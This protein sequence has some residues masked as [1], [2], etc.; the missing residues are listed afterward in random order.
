MNQKG[1]RKHTD[2]DAYK[3]FVFR[4]WIWQFMLRASTGRRSVWVWKSC[5]KPWM[6]LFLFLKFISIL[7]E[8]Y[9]VKFCGGNKFAE[10][11]FTGSKV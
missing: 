9:T 4:N 8:I 3:Y 1:I 10:N 5:D 11:N 7:Y 6:I 2:E